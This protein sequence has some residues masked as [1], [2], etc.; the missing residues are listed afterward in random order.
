MYDLLGGVTQEVVDVDAASL[1]RLIKAAT[2]LDMQKLQLL[3][4]VKVRTELCSVCIA[5]KWIYACLE[6]YKFCTGL[7]TLLVCLMIGCRP[8]HGS[9][10]G[11]AKKCSRSLESS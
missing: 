10:I 6:A 7:C 2:I 5:L 4:V 1:Q 3:A 9:C 11:R 8:L